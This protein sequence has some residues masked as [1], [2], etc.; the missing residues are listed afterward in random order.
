MRLGVNIVLHA[1]V[2]HKLNFE[3]RRIVINN[4]QICRYLVLELR[5][6]Y[7]IRFGNYFVLHL[8]TLHPLT[9]A[10]PQV[11]HRSCVCGLDRPCSWLL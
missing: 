3:V 10:G 2:R 9:S 6:K 1:N 8:D 11:V 4:D 7:P 5:Q